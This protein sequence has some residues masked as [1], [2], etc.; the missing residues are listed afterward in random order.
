MLLFKSLHEKGPLES[1]IGGVGVGVVVEGISGRLQKR[2]WR[3]GKEA[4][5][6]FASM[7]FVYLPELYLALGDAGI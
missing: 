5:N 1:R 4:T 3:K 7:D 6:S 2:E